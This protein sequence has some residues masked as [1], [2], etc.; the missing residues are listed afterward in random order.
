MS[1]IV[2]HPLVRDICSD[3]E[4]TKTDAS[5]SDENLVKWARAILTLPSAKTKALFDPSKADVKAVPKKKGRDTYDSL[6][7]SRPR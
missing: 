2:L 3:M 4:V 1:E 5:L 6:T 7:H